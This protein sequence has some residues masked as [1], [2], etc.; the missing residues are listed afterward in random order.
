ML[1]GVSAITVT[2]G[3]SL[4]RGQTP[5]LMLALGL[6]VAGATFVLDKLLV[7]RLN[8]MRPRQSLL[9]L[10]LC[11]FPL[12][13]ASTALATITTFSWLV[14]EIARRDLDESR[15]T[16]WTR[17]AEKIT[18]YLLQL[19]TALRRQAETVQSD[20]DGERRR[21]AAARREGT[22]YSL[23][24]LGTLVRRA[25]ATR[26]LEKRIAAFHP[27]PVDLPG[28]AAT[29]RDQIERALGDLAD[30]HATAL[31]VATQPPVFPAYEPFQPPS[32]DLQSVLAEE[33]RKRSWRAITAWGS[34][35]WV[36]V[37]PLFALWRGG[38]KIS[39]AVRLLQWRSRVK[40]AIDAALGRGAP[41]P[42]PIIIEPLHVRGIVRVAL[43]AEY[44]L[45]DCAPMLEEAVGTLTTVL[46][47]YQLN[48]VSTARGDVVDENIP[49]LPQLNGDPLVLSVVEARQ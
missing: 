38:R 27:L 21:A 11:W 33:T 23:E 35:L 46:G 20:I 42:L 7:E 15:R 16:H 40:D 43:P 17:E 6:G 8:A 34:A 24:A 37:L 49:L 28:D 32:T 10:L 4:L 48:R 19:R 31:V 9:S 30:L 25:A 45:N 39:L 36:E 13:L 5:I 2:T 44:T 1:A 26:D 18:T 3:A 29:A 12:L 47:P 14:P 41:T 22:P